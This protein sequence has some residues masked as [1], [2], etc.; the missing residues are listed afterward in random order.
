VASFILDI[1]DNDLPFASL[2]GK[3]LRLELKQLGLCH[4]R[5]TTKAKGSPVKAAFC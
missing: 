5:H 3:Y 2:G 1:T 4:A